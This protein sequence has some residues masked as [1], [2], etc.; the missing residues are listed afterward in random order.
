M[1]PTYIRLV[2]QIRHQTEENEDIP[3]SYILVI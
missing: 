2:D 3:V 1:Q